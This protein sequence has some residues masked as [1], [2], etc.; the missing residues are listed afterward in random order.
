[1]TNQKRLERIFRT[2]GEAGFSEAY[3]RS[4]LPAWWDDQAAKSPAGLSEFNL[5]LSRNLGLDVQGLSAD[6]PQVHFRLPHVRNFKRSVKYTESQLTPAVSVALSAARIAAKS[7][8][9]S[10]TP[11]PSAKELRKI[12]LA[13]GAK[14]VSLRSLLITCWR[15]GIPVIHVSKFDD[16]MPKMDG[17]SAIVFGR[18]VIVISKQTPFSAWMGFVLAHEM[19]HVAF[20]HCEDDEL[21]VDVSL[22]EE[23]IEVTEPDSQ[24][25]E[26]DGYA[27]QLL[28][29]DYDI[30]ELV[31]LEQTPEALAYA[32]MDIQRKFQIDAGHLLLKHAYKTNN[33]KLAITALKGLDTENRARN[34][35]LN[36]MKF[37]LN[38]YAV[39]SSSFG[40]LYRVC[41]AVVIE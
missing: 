39:A 15:H 4:L 38:P 10:Y 31:K 25:R 8:R 1:M 40:F 3:V 13:S 7:V 18:P 34:D 14:Y 16:G 35:I 33:W 5:A 9:A 41:G 27:M 30:S 2:L 20:H 37:E 29:G 28:S 19:G 11:L 26:A 21:I 17:L 23:T 6:N 36:A 12:I 24:E 32:A 22:S